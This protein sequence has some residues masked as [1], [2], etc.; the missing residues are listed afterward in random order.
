MFRNMRRSR[1]ELDQKACEDILN[2]GTSGVLAVL[3]DEDYPY[4]VPLSFFY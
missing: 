3:G 2:R 1:Q 4:A